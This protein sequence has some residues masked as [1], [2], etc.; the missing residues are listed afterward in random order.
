MQFGNESHKHWFSSKYIQMVV[1]A[2]E[3]AK[4]KSL[5]KWFVWNMKEVV[6]P[7]INM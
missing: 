1:E 4:F 5:T 7:S 6:W 2:P 3:Y